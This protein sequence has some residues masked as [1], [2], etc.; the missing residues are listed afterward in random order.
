MTGCPAV[1]G[2]PGHELQ[3][4]G[5]SAPLGSREEDIRVLYASKDWLTAQA[6]IEKYAIEYI[7]IGELERSTY[8]VYENKFQDNMPIIFKNDAVTI[9]EWKNDE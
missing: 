6:I 3:W 2:W 5:S 1:L 8:P 7:F 4:R 9:F